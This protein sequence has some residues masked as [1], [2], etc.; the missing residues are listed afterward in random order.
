MRRERRRVK[1][2]GREAKRQLDVDVNEE[3]TI[4]AQRNL[5]GEESG[6]R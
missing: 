1:K 2:L 3:I 5:Q 6:D 4:A